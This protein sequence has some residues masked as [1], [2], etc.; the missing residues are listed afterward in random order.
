MNMGGTASGNVI[1]SH[2]LGAIP[3]VTF[4]GSQQGNIGLVVAYSI[5]SI[6]TTQMT[7]YGQATSAPGGPYAIA[8]AAIL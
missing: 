2:N 4:A 5:G 3:T 1:V 8:W 7:I 6:T